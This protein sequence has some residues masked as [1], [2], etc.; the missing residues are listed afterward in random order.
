M[1]Y[2]APITDYVKKSTGDYIQQTKYIKTVLFPFVYS[3]DEPF[4]KGVYFNHPLDTIY[5]PF[6]IPIEVL[7]LSN[8][9]LIGSTDTNTTISLKCSWDYG[10]IGQ[11][12]NTHSA[13]SVNSQTTGLTLNNISYLNLPSTFTSNL[14]S[15]DIGVLKI[16]PGIAADF[17]GYIYGLHIQ[18]TVRE[19]G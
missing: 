4:T 17:F 13:S 19:A 8:I 7:V 6:E 5:I 15:G 14:E 3:T 11:S 10:K 16:E 2:L 18:F 9:Y 1:K 12:N